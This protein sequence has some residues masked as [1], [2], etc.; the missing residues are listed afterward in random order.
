MVRAAAARLHHAPVLAVPGGLP[1]LADGRVV[2][3]LGVG[4]AEPRCCLK[5]AHAA[6]GP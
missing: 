5:L 4:G 3:G 2:A 1:V 6:L